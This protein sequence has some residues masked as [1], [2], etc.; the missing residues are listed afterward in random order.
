[1]GM[2]NGYLLKLHKGK[3]IDF[4]ITEHDAKILSLFLREKS[5]C[6][7]DV[8]KLLKT[9]GTKVDYKNVHKKIWKLRDLELIE[10][11]KVVAKRHGA[12]YYRLTSFGI[13]MLFRF[14]K[15]IKLDLH[16]FLDHYGNDDSLRIL[17]FRYMNK[18]TFQAL[19]QNPG[20]NFIRSYLADCFD[21]IETQGLDSNSLKNGQGT[22]DELVKSDG[23]TPLETQ[24]FL[25][26]ENFV[27][28]V[29][30]QYFYYYRQRQLNPDGLKIFEAI[31]HDKKFMTLLKHTANFFNEYI[32]EFSRI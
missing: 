27:S 12:I 23:I 32:N 1:M 26:A 22:S 28:R 6:S 11:W 8:S 21:L 7:Y 20:Y 16:G 5:L 9:D 4:K 14:S 29:I 25:C 10:K 30:L 31:M 18:E 3:D 15:N 19:C 24:L 13:R 2:L 17:V